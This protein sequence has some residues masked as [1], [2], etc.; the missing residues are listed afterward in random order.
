[1]EISK[2]IIFLSGAISTDENYRQKFAEA[3]RKL[4]EQG[5]IVINPTCLNPNLPYEV[6][7][8]ICFAMIDASDE[9]YMIGDDWKH[10]R[11]AWRE[12]M[13]AHSKGKKIVGGWK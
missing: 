8:Q 7:M 13:Y 2:P 5:Y 10:S 1:M 4:T 12:W 9:F 3:E 11:G 6:L